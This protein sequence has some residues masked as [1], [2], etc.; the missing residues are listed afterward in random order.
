MKAAQHSDSCLANEN[1]IEYCGKG[2]VYL[3]GEEFTSLATK[4]AMQIGDE[5]TDIGR[6]LW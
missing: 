4:M 5:R 6:C 2:I 1:P 3:E